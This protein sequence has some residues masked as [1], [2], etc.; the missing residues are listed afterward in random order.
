MSTNLSTEKFDVYTYNLISNE[1]NSLVVE[2]QSNFFNKYFNLVFDTLHLG[3]DFNFTLWGNALKINTKNKLE[4]I[5]LK[6]KQSNQNDTFQ[7]VVFAIVD[8]FR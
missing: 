2:L 7:I 5:K 4:R 6:N 1:V 8:L 3:V